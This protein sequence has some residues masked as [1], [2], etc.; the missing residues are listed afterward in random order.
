MSFSH[1]STNGMPQSLR[2]LVKQS[3][4][5]R[6]SKDFLNRPS[7]SGNYKDKYNNLL[8]SLPTRLTNYLKKKLYYK[9]N[10]ITGF[11]LSP[12]QEFHITG[13]DKKLIRKYFNNKSKPKPKQYFPSKAFRNN[14]PRVPKNIK[15]TFE[16]P[17]N[18]GM[19]VP[20]KGETYYNGPV[21]NSF[22]LD[23]RDFSDSFKNP[24]A[25]GR[26]S[27]RADI[28]RHEMLRDDVSF[29]FNLDD[30]RFDPRS[31]PEMMRDQFESKLPS[32]TGYKYFPKHHHIHNHSK[33]NSQY[34]ITPESYTDRDPR[35][36]YII[37]DLSKKKQG[38]YQNNLSVNYRGY[39]NSCPSYSK[40]QRE[41]I[42]GKSY[43]DTKNKVVVPK[44]AT[45]SKDLNTY[46][47][48]M[49]KYAH[50]YNNFIDRDVETALTRGMPHHTRRSYGYRNPE[51]HY[52]DFLPD[53]FVNEER[54]WH[55]ARG[56]VSTRR[57]NKAMAE[58][59][60]HHRGVY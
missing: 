9:K 22:M 21:N 18:M 20:N 36:K 46:G 12:E 5:A 47:Y 7:A 58:Q 23:A 33:Y 43:M 3:A 37:S 59:Q 31:D 15:N 4:I 11:R 24:L 30:T 13:A 42:G 44:I 50:T 28:Q 10:H 16:K 6:K 56:G 40:K 32:G 17:I 51:A 48:T 1:Y 26:V 45:K 2:D 25:L 55:G 19:F 38:K 57:D 35:N 60:F 41:I 27:E 53:D 29:G 54:V 49:M 39:D 14:D 34:R 8:T 52:F